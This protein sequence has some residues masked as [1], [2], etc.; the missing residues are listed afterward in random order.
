METLENLFE[1]NKFLETYSLP[2]LSHDEIENLNRPSTSKE[3]ESIVKNLP[4]DKS[5]GPDAFTGGFN[6]TF[7]EE[8]TSILPKLFSKIKRAE[9]PWGRSG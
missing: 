5:L 2:R 8:L 9:F 7:Q 1:G 3:I 6:Q 4:T